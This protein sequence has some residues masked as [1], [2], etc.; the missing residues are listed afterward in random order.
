MTRR[1]HTAKDRARIFAAAGGICH[2]C[3]GPIQTG[4]AWEVEHVIALELSGDDTDANKR[5][6][7]VKC[8]KAKTADDMGKIAKAKRNEARHTGAARPKGQ[9]KPAGFPKREAREPKPGLPPRQMY[10]SAE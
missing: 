6:A 8:H 1:R 3:S 4:D 9:I 2:I 5:P 7:H 10:R